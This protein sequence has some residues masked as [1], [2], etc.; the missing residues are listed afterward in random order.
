MFKAFTVCSLLFWLEL[1][2]TKISLTFD[3]LVWKI[4]LGRLFQ[5]I[6]VHLDRFNTYLH[7][8][9]DEG[10]LINIIHKIYSFW[11]ALVPLSLKIDM[12]RFLIVFQRVN[13]IATVCTMDS[14]MNRAR[15]MIK[16]IQQWLDHLIGL[17]RNFA[18]I[19]YFLFYSLSDN[20]NNAVSKTVD[21]DYCYLG[22]F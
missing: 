10:T 19:D 15:L 12:N 3:L 18:Q 20:I 11:D 13:A 5:K 1:S 17:S 8:I 22:Y 7:K 2:S 4:R 14:L 16:I 6:K 21:Y 9:E